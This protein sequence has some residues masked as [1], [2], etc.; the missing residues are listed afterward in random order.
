MDRAA[1]Y[2]ETSDNLPNSC[3]GYRQNSGLIQFFSCFVCLY[4][5]DQEFISILD[6]CTNKRSMHCVSLC[7]NSN[8]IISVSKSLY[9]KNGIKLRKEKLSYTIDL[10]LV[11]KQIECHSLKSTTIRHT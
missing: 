11:C 8:R 9:N 10:E 1:A 7:P 5:L 4:R 3:R 6:F 2:L